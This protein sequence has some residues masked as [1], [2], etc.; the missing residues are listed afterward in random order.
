M[1]VE[2]HM[3][4][5]CCVATPKERDCGRSSTC[6]EHKVRLVVTDRCID[7]LNLAMNLNIVY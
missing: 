1:S 6:G 5:D 3:L 4:R 7:E 2:L